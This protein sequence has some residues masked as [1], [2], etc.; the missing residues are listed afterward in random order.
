MPPLD[1]SQGHVVITT[2]PRFLQNHWLPVH[3]E[4]CSR[5]WSWCGNVLTALLPATSPNSG[6]PVASVSG[7]QHLRSS[8]GLLNIPESEPR[9]T[10]GA[11]LSRDYL[12]ET[13]FLPIYGETR[14]DSAHFQVTTEGLSI[15][16]LMCWR[17]EGTFDHHRLALKKPQKNFFSKKTSFFPALPL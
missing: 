8:S 2:S 3:R 6:V 10:G 1:W 16:H 15:P 17:T 11:S 4:L 12:C 5:L 7:R 13:V 14:D 9:S